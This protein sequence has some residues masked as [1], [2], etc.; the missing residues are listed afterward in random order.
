MTEIDNKVL[1]KMLRDRRGSLKKDMFGNL[2]L[3]NQSETK[4]EKFKYRDK[5][6]D[7]KGRIEEVDCTIQT[8]NNMNGW[9]D[10]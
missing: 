5:V 9:N 7:V 10:W 4:V 1:L 3:Y 6:L 8:I 2:D